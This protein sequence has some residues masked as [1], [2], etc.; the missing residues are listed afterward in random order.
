[1]ELKM[2][3]RAVDISLAGHHESF[4]IAPHVHNEF[5]VEAAIEFAFKY[6]GAEDVGYNSI[7]G[8]GENATVL[9]YETNYEHFNSNQMFVL[10]AGAEY[11]G[12]TADITR[13][14]PADGTFSKEQKQI[15]T[16]VKNAQSAGQKEFVSGSSYFRVNFAIAMELGK[17][18]KK[19][20]AD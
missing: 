13:S 8:C 20:R 11:H 3:Q 7:V 19:I 5:Q 9:H 12:Y 6:H 15:Y 14:F 10:D 16:I 4:K 17:G 2:I 18:L 1:M